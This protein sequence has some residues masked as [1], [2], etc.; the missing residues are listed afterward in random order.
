VIDYNSDA[1]NSESDTEAK[2]KIRPLAQAFQ[3]M[4]NEEKKI[5]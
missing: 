2:K 1:E 4:E 5:E 3:L